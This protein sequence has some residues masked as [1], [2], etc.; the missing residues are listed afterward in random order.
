MPTTLLKKGEAWVELT[1]LTA[2]TA[3]VVDGNVFRPGDQVE[4]PPGFTW[5]ELSERG[6]DA[7]TVGHPADLELLF[8]AMTG[9]LRPSWT[10]AELSA[11]LSV[12]D[13]AAAA[14][15]EKT[16]DRLDLETLLARFPEEFPAAEER[17]ARSTEPQRRTRDVA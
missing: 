7:S 16:E 13:A 15:F 14:A 10:V 1:P 11:A 17:D 3:D 5:E 12:T 9:H 6:D 4:A 8:D 2:T